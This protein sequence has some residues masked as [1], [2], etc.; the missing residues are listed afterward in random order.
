MIYSALFIKSRITIT[1]TNCW[2]WKLSRDKYGYGTVSKISSGHGLAHR[3]SYSI[4][5]GDPA[6][7][8]VC[9]TCDNPP[10]VNP[11]HLFLATQ[12]VNVRD[13]IAKGR[14]VFTRPAWTPEIEAR[15]WLGIKKG[16]K[17][18]DIAKELGISETQVCKIKYSLLERFDNGQL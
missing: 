1:E 4:F 3:L 7:N 2:E 14:F 11:E 5:K 10:C 15:I 17:Q 12:E 13:A 6:G 16:E 8:S 18:R 9:H